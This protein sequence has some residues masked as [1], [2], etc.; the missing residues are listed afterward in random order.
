MFLLIIV[1]FNEKEVISRCEDAS[2]FFLRQY[3]QQ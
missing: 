3:V 1:N 2:Q